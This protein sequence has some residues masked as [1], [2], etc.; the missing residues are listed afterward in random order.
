MKTKGPIFLWIVLLFLFYEAAETQAATYTLTITTNNGSVIVTPDKALYDEGE[1]VKLTPKPDVGYNFTGWAGDAHG[2]RL[3]LN[4]TMDSDKTIIANFDTWRPPIGIPEPEFGIF[5]TYRMYDDPANRNPEL[6]YHQNAEGGY[7]TNYVDNTHP[8]ATDTDNPY[9]TADKPRKTILRYPEVIPPGSVVEIHGGPYS[10]K[11]GW[12]LHLNGTASQPIFFRGYSSDVTDMPEFL[13]I[14]YDGYGLIPNGQYFILENLHMNSSGIKVRPKIAIDSI[15]HFSIRN[16]ESSGAGILKFY[17]NIVVSGS[18]ETS[19]HDA[20]VY[21]NHIHHHGD[22]IDPGQVDVCGVVPAGNISYVWVIDNHMHHNGGDS[23]QVATKGQGHHIYIGRNIMHSDGENAIDIKGTND[24]IISEN[25]MYDYY[26]AGLGGQG[27]VVVLHIQSSEPGPERNWL[28]HNYL[29]DANSGITSSSGTQ[30]IYTIGNIIH[31]IN[32]AG[33]NGWNGEYFYHIGNT[34]YN[35]GGGISATS[36]TAAFITNNIV[37]NLKSVESNHL[38]VKYSPMSD[39]SEANYNL[40]YQ[41]NGEVNIDWGT[42]TNY[43]VSE[44]KSAYPDK[45]KGCI[46]ADPLFADPESNNFSLQADSPAID[47]GIESEVYQTFYDLYGID[48]RKDIEARTRPQGAGWD[49]GAYEYTLAAIN[50][51]A[52]SVTSQNSVSLTW[53]VPGEEGVTGKPARYDIRYADSE[54]TDANWDAATQVQGEPVVGDFG[55]TQSFTIT[56]LNAGATYYA[57]IKTG[58]EVGHTSELSNV[59]SGTT[60]T[61]G[62]HAPVLESIGDRSVVENGT[63]TFVISATDADVG[64]TLT[65]S[66]TSIPTG[67]DFDSATQTFAW[68]PTNTQEGI[69]HVTFLV[70]DGQ[71]T[72]S[73]TITITVLDSDNRPPVLAAIGDKSV[74]ENASLSFS[75]SAT[76]PDEDDLTYSATDLPSGASFANQTF[77]WIPTYDQAG[78]Y[79]VTFEVSDGTVAVSETITI[80]V[81]ESNRAPVLAAIGNQ[82]VNENAL[83]SFPVSATDPDEN[84]LTYPVSGMPSGANFSN[85]VLNWIPTYDQAGSYSVTFTVSDGELTDSEQITITVVNVTDMA[86]PSAHDFYPLPDSIQVPLNCLITLTISDDGWGVDANT[87]TLHVNDQL[88]YSGN[89]AAYESAYGI[90]R[91]TG[92]QASYRYYYHPTNI[93]DFDQQVSVRVNASDMANNT[94][95]PVS[96]QFVTEMRSFGKNKKVSSFSSVLSE[97]IPVTV[98]DSIGNIWAAW[99]A[100]PSGSRNIYVSMLA[101]ETDHFTETIPLTNDVYDKCNPAMAIGTDD[102]L[103]I[104]WQDNTRG[105]WDI[106]VSTSFDG[107]NWSDI[108]RV[109]DSNDNE[110]NPA[111]AVDNGS[112]NRAYIVWQDGRNGNQDIYVASSNN[113]FVTST[114]SQ[115]TSHSADQLE[116]DIAIDSDNTVYAVWMDTRN[117]SNDIYGA[118]SNTGPWTNVPIVNNTYNQANPTIAAEPT[119]STLHLLWVDCTAGN[120]DIFYGASNGLPLSPISGSTIIDDTTDADQSAPA[121]IAAR[122]YWNNSHVYACWQDNRSVGESDLYFAEIKSGTAGTNILVGDDGT[123]S[124]QSDP[125]LGFDEYGQPVILWADDRDSTTR[126]YGACSTYFE[127]VALASALII[128]A[129]GGRVGE[130]PNFI[131]DNEDISIEILPNAYDCDMVISISKIENPQKFRSPCITAY[132]IGPS[133]MQFS[134]P[135]IVTIPYTSSGSG[136]AIPYWYNTQTG[137]LS[138]QGITDITNTTLANGVSVASF[139]TTHLTTFYIL[140]ET[141]ESDDRTGNGFRDFSGG[142]GGGGG[143]SLS[144]FKEGNIVEYLLPYGA[145]VLIMFILKRRDRRYKGG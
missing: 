80:T 26:T 121:I 120:L 107:Q 51:L 3:V 142:G 94:M 135:A 92:T 134:S 115:I 109:T 65:Y 97:D 136:Q 34:I 50:D 20:I 117:G 89:T 129:E 114:L 2:K 69:Y 79:S 57:A 54:I 16:I 9:G 13:G 77:S 41:E 70:T 43:N 125:A 130:D 141:S 53:T 86:P 101:I 133:G 30:S 85:Q 128:S 45:S 28:I 55:D 38:R 87:V 31:D 56:G 73:E 44:F 63:L 95:A 143:C 59:V 127:P 25:T 122:D 139:K 8:N 71:V 66:A 110:V 37:A 72:V 132:E 33:I 138:Q 5:E 29:H 12:I 88:V 102:T 100:G 145:L 47:A 108:I 106:C 49:I 83:L 74:N 48:I 90:C 82:S 58:N 116:P 99:H 22:P 27:E 111:I 105:S 23:I 60:A 113:R 81:H 137:T 61:S 64:D 6:T 98:T 78:S 144:Y 11:Y 96:Y 35:T 112:P 91:R 76:D 7:Y 17:D 15:H 39:V 52:V 4:L 67:A 93:F 18:S 68:T 131:D 19:I 10:K 24:V 14:D 140:E 1:V 126:I 21:N 62:N 40:F 124:N 75:I 118:A 84:A 32:G 104:V 119:N 46:E 123:N 103:Y 42:D 36:S